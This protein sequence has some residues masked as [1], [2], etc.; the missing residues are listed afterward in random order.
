MKNDCECKQKAQ[1]KK[2]ITIEKNISR[3][4]RGGNEQAGDF[5]LSLV[6]MNSFKIWLMI[7]DW[8]YAWNENLTFHLFFHLSL[9]RINHCAHNNILFVCNMRECLSRLNRIQSIGPVVKLSSLNK[10]FQHPMQSNIYTHTTRRNTQILWLT[11]GFLFHFFFS[12]NV[13]TFKWIDKKKSVSLHRQAHLL[14]FLFRYEYICYCCCYCRCCSAKC[15]FW[16]L[17]SEGKK[18]GLKVQVYSGFWS[19]KFVRAAYSTVAQ[20]W[21]ARIFYF[22]LSLY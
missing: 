4:Y 15:C 7:V 21:C 8:I 18:K 19:Y 6:N 2:K 13:K 16:Y 20:P 3:E 5:S 14:Y 17:E 10:P 9:L 12:F 22:F 11:F 1:I